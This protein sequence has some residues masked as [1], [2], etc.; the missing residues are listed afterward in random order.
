M[1][2]KQH[3]RPC[4]GIEI[5]SSP[6]FPELNNN[7]L[8]ANVITI[9]GILNY[10]LTEDKSGLVGTEVSTLVSATSRASARRM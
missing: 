9:Q 7:L 5:C 3:T 8:V 1:V 4:P 6:I 2:Y 10:K